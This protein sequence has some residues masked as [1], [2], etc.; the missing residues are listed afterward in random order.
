MQADI[1]P[2]HVAGHRG[3][4]GSAIVRRLRA[5]G[6]RQLLLRTHDELDLTDQHA[7]EAFFA[8]HRPRKLLDS[9]RLAALGW[10]PKIPPVEGMSEAYGWFTSHHAGA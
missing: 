1:G 3:L 9:S 10:T 7:V 8:E 2:I 5:A 6:E 4:V